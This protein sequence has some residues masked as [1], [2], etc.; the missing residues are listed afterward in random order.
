MSS[1]PYIEPHQSKKPN[2][3]SASAYGT[4]SDD[5][6]QSLSLLFQTYID[7]AREEG[8]AESKEEINALKKE[9]EEL[10][11][12][13]KS[14]KSS[15]YLRKE[16][17]HYGEYYYNEFIFTNRN[18]DDIIDILIDLCSMKREKGRFVI[19]YKTD[20]YIVWKVLKCFKQIRCDISDF[21]T[22][23]NDCVIPYIKDKD[24]R[25]KIAPGISNYNTMD[26][27]NKAFNVE[28]LAWER[29]L[30]REKENETTKKHGISMLDRG[31]NILLKLKKMLA[32]RD[33]DV[34]YKPLHYIK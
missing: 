14:G 7:E 27:E 25:K 22:L 24:R 23:V 20:W 8:R 34:Q 11:A 21:L 32:S 4:S 18:G 30:E 33:I 19:A 5:A 9:I 31:V 12:K 2:S 29:E 28:V 13:L 6:L 26:E 16:N 3:P 17:G 10:K 1:F 15:E